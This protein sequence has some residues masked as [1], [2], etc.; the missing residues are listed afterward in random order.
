MVIIGIDPHPDSHTAAALD[1][2]G[3][4]L[5]QLVV[6]NDAVGLERLGAWMESYEVS[7]V[8]IEGANNPFA[9]KFSTQLVHKGYQLLDIS[10]SLTSQ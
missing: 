3:K 2:N 4:V 8:A 1:D 9:R 10:P 7:K 6:L 5:G